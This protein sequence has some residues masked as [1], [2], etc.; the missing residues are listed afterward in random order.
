MW[1]FKKKQENKTIR[2]KCE[3]PTPMHFYVSKVSD[4]A[5]E[6]KK[7]V[8]TD[9]LEVL[10]KYYSELVLSDGNLIKVMKSPVDELFL[11]EMPYPRKELYINKKEANIVFEAQNTLF[12][13]QDIQ[14]PAISIAR[15]IMKDVHSLQWSITKRVGNSSPYRSVDYYTIV[16]DVNDVSINFYVNTP[17]DMRMVITPKIMSDSV[18]ASSFTEDELNLLVKAVEYL[19]RKKV[20]LHQKQAR[21]DLSRIYNRNEESRRF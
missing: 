21:A 18:Y 11:P 8:I 9:P 20:D 3:E 16:D 2:N 5:Y 14:E 12:K 7:G 15:S 6:L 1:P 17:T 10:V 19:Y 4:L 13:G